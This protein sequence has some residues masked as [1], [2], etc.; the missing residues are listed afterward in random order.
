[1]KAHGRVC[2]SK[3]GYSAVARTARA[4]T[5][6]PTQRA[7]GE[8]TSAEETAAL[9]SPS[10][11]GSAVVVVVVVVVVGASVQPVQV[12]VASSVAVAAV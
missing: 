6:P 7:A 10:F 5:E 2:V 3:M 1:M 12:Q 4:R 8:L 9:L 11:F